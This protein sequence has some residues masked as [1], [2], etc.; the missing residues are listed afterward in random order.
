MQIG[1][2]MAKRVQLFSDE[3]YR[4][5]E[6]VEVRELTNEDTVYDE[7]TLDALLND[8]VDAGVVRFVE[9]MPKSIRWIVKL[10]ANKRYYNYYNWK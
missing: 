3:D 8:E 10:W 9:D 1:E 4:Y 2:I 7:C 6:E 5:Y